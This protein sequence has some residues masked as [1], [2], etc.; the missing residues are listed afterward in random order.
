[1]VSYDMTT[2]DMTTA[3]LRPKARKPV[4]IVPAEDPWTILYT[5]KALVDTA[6]T[7]KQLRAE[8]A[9]IRRRWEPKP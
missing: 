1:V 9:A 4:L 6:D 3:G 8:I 7:A 5:C 2:N